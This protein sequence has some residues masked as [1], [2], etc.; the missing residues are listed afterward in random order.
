MRAPNPAWNANKLPN[1]SQETKGRGESHK[2]T[3]K[4]WIGKG[5]VRSVSGSGL[6]FPSGVSFS[7]F[8]H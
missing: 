1:A 5:A 8:H 4:P 2:R 3:L 6:T 7:L